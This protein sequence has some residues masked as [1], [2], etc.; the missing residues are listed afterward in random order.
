[1]TKTNR[2]NTKRFLRAQR[3]QMAASRSKMRRYKLNR[4]R[5][6]RSAGGRQILYYKHTSMRLLRVSS[7]P[8]TRGKSNDSNTA[9]SFQ[10]CKAHL[11]VEYCAGSLKSPTEVV[12]RKSRPPVSSLSLGKSVANPPPFLQRRGV[13]V[14]ELKSKYP[15][16]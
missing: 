13:T 3:K 15:V 11:P 10:K 1:M 12:T 16:P 8:R 14:Q 7:A 5:R 9:L 4:A 2:T 6:P